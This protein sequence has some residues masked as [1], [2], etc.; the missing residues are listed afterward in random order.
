MDSTH[1]CLGS[2]LRQCGHGNYRNYI[3]TTNEPSHVDCELKYCKNFEFCNTR[4]PE[5]V[6]ALN[7]GKCLECHLL[8]ITTIIKDKV[9][10][11]CNKFSKSILQ[12]PTC[13]LKI[14]HE[15]CLE[16][17]SS[18]NRRPQYKMCTCIDDDDFKEEEE[19]EEE[20]EDDDDDDNN[21]N[22]KD[23]VLKSCILCKS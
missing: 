1:C 2:C 8:D 9:C 13:L 17:V 18:T 20:E 12:H 3:K 22:D 4:N 23:L 19:E 5:W 14:K 15:Y 11:S 16:C 6:L 7:D 10:M 21:D